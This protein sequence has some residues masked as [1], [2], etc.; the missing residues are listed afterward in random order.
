LPRAD[1]EAVSSDRAVG[2]TV[3]GGAETIL[4]VEDDPAVRQ[5]V[6]TQ[7]RSLGYKTIVATNATEALAIIDRGEPFDLLFTDL[8][9]PGPMTGRHLADEAAK[10]RSELKVLFTS[11]YTEDSV[12]HH[13]R[14]NPGVLL[15]TKPYRKADLARMIRQALAS[16]EPEKVAR[17]AG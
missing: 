1:K 12:V 6:D 4:L 15:L 7:V 13:G 2:Q 17:A 5:S 9:M 11:G 8:I 16:G 10:R 14:L 3:Q